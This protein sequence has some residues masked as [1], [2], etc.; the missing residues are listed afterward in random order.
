MAVSEKLPGRRYT[1]AAIDVV[2]NAPHLPTV[3]LTGQVMRA[4][5]VIRGQHVPERTCG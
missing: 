5:F 2:M 3:R 1:S 4:S